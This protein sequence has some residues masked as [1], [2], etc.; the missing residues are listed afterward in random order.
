[1]LPPA[2]SN[3]PTKSRRGRCVPQT[4][5]R[6]PCRGRWSSMSPASFPSGGPRRRNRKPAGID[7]LLPHFRSLLR[8]AGRALAY[9]RHSRNERLWSGPA[10]GAL[11]GFGY[12][13][14][15]TSRPGRLAHI[16]RRSRWVGSCRGGNLATAIRGCV[17][18]DG[19]C[20][21]AF[22]KS[23]SAD[24]QRHQAVCRPCDRGRIAPGAVPATVEG[25]HR[26]GRSTPSSHCR[27]WRSYKKVLCDHGSTGHDEL[28]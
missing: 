7:L 12:G 28:S 4:I 17:S 27:T 23:E 14:P 6:R 25:E 26:P 5:C 11:Y 10:R 13:L 3:R 9:K 24:D 18:A 1:M 20:R 19:L 8:R 15:L 16:A 22:Q 2:C 21:K